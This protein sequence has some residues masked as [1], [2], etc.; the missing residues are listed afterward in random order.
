M[1]PLVTMPM[2]NSKYQLLLLLFI[3]ENSAAALLCPKCVSV[4]CDS[5]SQPVTTRGLSSG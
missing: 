2:T 4:T 5:H 3:S 1:R